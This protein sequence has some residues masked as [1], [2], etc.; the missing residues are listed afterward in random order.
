MEYRAMSFLSGVPKIAF[1]VLKSHFPLCHVDVLVSA[2]GKSLRLIVTD[3]GGLCAEHDLAAI[4]VHDRA[5]EVL[6]AALHALADVFETPSHW[7]AL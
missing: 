4:A 2:N 7:M 3:S 1:E 5:L 6:K